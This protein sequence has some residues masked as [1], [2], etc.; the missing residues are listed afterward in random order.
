[1]HRIAVMRHVITIM[2][3]VGL[4]IG[5]DRKHDEVATT[6]INSTASASQAPVKDK[7]PDQDAKP[8]AMQSASNTA[9]NLSLEFTPSECKP[10]HSVECVAKLK[11]GDGWH[12]YAMKGGAGPS[13]PTR[14]KLDLPPWLGEEGDW[15]APTPE[16]NLS[17]FGPEAIHTGELSISR[18]LTISYDAPTGLHH[19]PCSVTLQAC[20]ATRCLPPE[21]FSLS[22]PITVLSE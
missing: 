2:L 5:C 10:G 21:T 17:H 16:V 13:Q 7:S 1:M 18:K 9:V 20:N 12:I 6:S 22:L 11:I 8:T 19:V 14:L 15:T 4:S 3:A